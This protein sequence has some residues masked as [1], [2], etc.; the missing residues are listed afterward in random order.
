MQVQAIY[1][2]GRIEFVEPL[3]LKRDHIRLVVTVPD[4][5]IAI[6]QDQ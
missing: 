5:E 4:D 6:P 3:R 1:N 2:Q